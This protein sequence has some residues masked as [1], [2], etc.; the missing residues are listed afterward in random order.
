MHVLPEE[1]ELV[2]F[3][4]GIPYL[5]SFGLHVLELAKSLPKIAR[6]P[7]VCRFRCKHVQ[8]TLVGEFPLLEG[9]VLGDLGVESLQMLSRRGSK[10]EDTS[11]NDDGG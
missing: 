9:E 8:S 5:F 6:T 11:G 2:A 7:T 10:Q 3:H 4:E 1:V